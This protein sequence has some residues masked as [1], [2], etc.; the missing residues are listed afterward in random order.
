MQRLPSPA[1]AFSRIPGHSGY[2]PSRYVTCLAPSARCTWTSYSGYSAQLRLKRQTYVHI[3]SS[4]MGNAMSMG[5]ASILTTKEIADETWSA[6]SQSSWPC[7]ALRV[8]CMEY[9]NL[10]LCITTEQRK[11]HF[12]KV[13]F[14]IARDRY[15]FLSPSL[16]SSTPQPKG[17]LRI[18][19][20]L[21]TLHV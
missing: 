16:L 7:R 15:L 4:E 8:I 17:C 2:F 18:G 19:S 6:S 14:R 5:K 3:S 13:D 9:R 10:S 12:V 1:T 20:R 21:V 11:H